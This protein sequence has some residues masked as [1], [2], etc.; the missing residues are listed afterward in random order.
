M[1]PVIS[2]R[3]QFASRIWAEAK[4]LNENLLLRQPQEHIQGIAY[5]CW[6]VKLRIYGRIYLETKYVENVEFW[7]VFKCNKKFKLF[8]KEE[9]E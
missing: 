9:E 3:T 8:R 2:F 7:I 5:V 4:Q 6:C 1:M